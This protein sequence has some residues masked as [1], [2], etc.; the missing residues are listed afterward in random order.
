VDE[1]SSSPLYVIDTSSLIQLQP[2]LRRTF[3]LLWNRMDQ[4]ADA[5]RAVVP[6]EVQRELGDD[7]AEAQVRWLRDHPAI[8]RG[9]AELWDRARLVANRYPDLVDLAKPGSGDPF[10]IALALAEREQHQ[11][12]L[13]P[14]PVIVVAEEHSKR[15]SKVAI[16]DAC[17]D[18]GL[19][20]VRLQGLF[21]SEGWTDL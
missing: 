16:P 19:R 15:P 17:D 14:R 12:T 13:W 1:P 7:E 11:A 6:E 4:L 20:V 3:G 9:T 5:Q 10:V 8:V 2:L 18:Y 21:D